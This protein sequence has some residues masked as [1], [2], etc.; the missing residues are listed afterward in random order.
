MCI[1]Y[2]IDLQKVCIGIPLAEHKVCTGCARC[3]LCQLGAHWTMALESISQ[4]TLGLLASRPVEAP[5]SNQHGSISRP[6]RGPCRKISL[7]PY[8]GKYHVC[9]KVCKG[10]HKVCISLSLLT[11]STLVMQQQKSVPD[12]HFCNNLHY[13]CT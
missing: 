8:N 6:P 4:T 1:K 2:G 5:G 7:L 3:R 12:A 11:L 10:L 9:K 13:V